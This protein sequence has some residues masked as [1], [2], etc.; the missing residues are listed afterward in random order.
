ME[1]NFFFCKI[2]FVRGYLVSRA[3]KRRNQIRLAMNQ[4][5]T[6][7]FLP[8]VR[9]NQLILLSGRVLLF[10]KFSAYE[11]NITPQGASYSPSPTTTPFRF[12]T[13]QKPTPWH[14]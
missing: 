3:Q 6:S 4:V 9:L 14:R 12:T 10:V 2:S 13:P 11:L 1:F 7:G 5:L 8:K